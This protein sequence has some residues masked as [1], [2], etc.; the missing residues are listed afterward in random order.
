M[1]FLEAI[2][3]T[4]VE[5][6]SKIIEYPI[7]I[8]N[9]N[10]YIIG[11]SDKKRLNTFHSVSMEVMERNEMICYDPEKVKEYENVLPGVA[12]PIILNN[13]TIGVLGVVGE[14]EEV[15]K[16]AQLV[17]S[18][19]ELMCHEYLKN[20]MSILESKTLDN[21][22]RYL[23]NSETKEDIEYSVRYG[24]MLGF[25][26][27]T[28][29]SR[30]SYLIEIDVGVES[31]I[32]EEHIPDRVAWQ[33][34]QNNI[35]EVLRYY[36]IDNNED[37]L[38]MLSLDQ[39]ILIKALQKDEPQELFTKRVEYNLNRLI[40]Y[41]NNEYNYKIN[42][43]VG[44][45]EKGPMGIKKSYQG[46]LKALN[47]GKKTQITPGIFYYNDWN[48]LFELVGVGLN[49]YVSERLDENLSEFLQH[50][51]FT[52]LA[53]TFM[54]YCNCNM[55]MSETARILYLH[56]NSLVYRMEK[57]RELTSLDI[58]RFD[59]CLLLY[60]AIKNSGFV[61]EQRQNELTLEDDADSAL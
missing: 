3:Q 7:S 10:G 19:V 26:L 16:Y 47:A 4:I 31:K 15:I 24:R 25:H 5:N 39:F 61:F 33:F 34:F 58:S 51:N 32:E 48:I 56:R 18:H 27:D 38:A 6:T 37:L 21:L 52:T 36:L 28:D 41:L 54:T 42:V 53:H 44:S 35:M 22:I 12:T 29:V 43:S 13:E 57:I 8:T 23:L 40:R 14:P 45:L 20:E 55:N 59:H 49:D 30:V 50:V 46:A 1:G 9:R 2:S 17:K 11:A 60:F